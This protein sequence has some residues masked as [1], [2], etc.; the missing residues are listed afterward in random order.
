MNDHYHDTIRM[1]FAY[2]AYALMWIAASAAVLGAVYIT[3]SG[4]CLWALLLP[5]CVSLKYRG[6]KDDK[7]EK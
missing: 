7:E 3:H 6:G 4:W 2:T 5:A 1:C